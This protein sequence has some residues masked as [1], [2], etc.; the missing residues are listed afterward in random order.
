MSACV[1]HMIRAMNRTPPLGV[2]QQLRRDV[3]FGCPAPTSEG[4]CGNPYLSWHHFDPP[5]AVRKH[6]EPQGMIALCTEHHNK[7]DAGAYTVEQLRAM[8]AASHDA[9]RGR[10]DW[11]RRALLIVAGGNFYFRTPVAVQLL[12]HPLVATQRDDD[13][14]LLLDVAM[15]T[16]SRAPRIAMKANFW[17]AHGAPTD[18]ECPPSGRLLHATYDNGDEL[19]IEF[20]DVPDI[21]RLTQRYPG[22]RADAWPLSYPISA[23][24]IQMTIAGTGIRFGPRDTEIAT[25]VMTNCFAGGGAVGLSIN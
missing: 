14:Y 16:T 5:W 9:I 20:F 13:G 23:A 7:A 25:N 18:L 11:M 1:T 15:A 17:L 12:G 22:V 21:A 24:E 10:F 3:G 8:K 2:R 4:I 6:H 19:R